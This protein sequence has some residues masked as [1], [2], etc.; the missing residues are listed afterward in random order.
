MA[1][2]ISSV[3]K[4]VYV[5]D[6]SLPSNQATIHGN[7]HHNPALVRFVDPLSQGVIQSTEREGKGSS[8]E[9]GEMNELGEVGTDGGMVEFAHGEKV[10]VDIVL[11]CT[12]DKRHGLLLFLI[13]L[14]LP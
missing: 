13:H 5:A 2:E 3:A 14:C 12:G 10:M 1:R 11:W 9:E 4:V 6:R 7:I 8:D